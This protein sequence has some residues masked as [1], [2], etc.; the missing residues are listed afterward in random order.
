MVASNLAEILKIQSSTIKS[1]ADLSLF[2]QFHTKTKKDK[3]NQYTTFAEDY[4][5]R[6]Q[7]AGVKIPKQF[8]A[9]TYNYHIQ[10][11]NVL[12]PEHVAKLFDPKVL[13]NFAVVD[14]GMHTLPIQTV[15]LQS[16]VFTSEVFKLYF[17]EIVKEYRK[18]ERGAK[19]QFLKEDYTEDEFKEMEHFYHNLRDSYDSASQ[20]KSEGG[21]E[22]DDDY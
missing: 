11:S 8:N 10:E 2:S 17:E 3:L 15:P 20:E 9:M 6:G 7:L 18:V 13:S 22:E 21:E 4:V 5:V 19:L 1:K 16:S 12:V 14:Q